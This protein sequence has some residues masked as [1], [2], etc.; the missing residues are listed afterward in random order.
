MVAKQIVVPLKRHDRIEEIVPYLEE[1]AKPGMRVLFLVPFGVESWACLRDHWITME[2]PIL[3]GKEIKAQK[4]SAEHGILAAR[5]ALRKMGVE[6]AV[7]I[8][9]GS[10]KKV[11]SSY[12]ANGDIHLSIVRTTSAARLMNLFVGC[13]FKRPGLPPVLFS[14]QVTR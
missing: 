14:I 13:P 2:S 5:D 3:A 4:G 9:A 6:I 8:Y 7:E 10:L 11:I 12:T 1:I